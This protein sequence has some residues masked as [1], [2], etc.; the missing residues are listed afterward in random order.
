M[1]VNKC[2]QLMCSSLDC[3][4]EG[5]ETHHLYIISNIITV[6]Q[7]NTKGHV[8]KQDTC[9]TFYKSDQY[10]GI[11]CCDH[12]Y[13]DVLVELICALFLT[14]KMFLASKASRSLPFGLP[15]VPLASAE[16]THKQQT[17]LHNTL[18]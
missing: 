3:H 12:A 9:Y 18:T 10:H 16:I 11:I 8:S 6:V 2:L 14:C 15:A 7:K 1:R 5:V 17:E 13:C 4:Q